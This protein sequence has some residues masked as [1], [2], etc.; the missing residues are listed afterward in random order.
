MAKPDFCRTYGIEEPVVLAGMAMVAEPEL[1]A[2]VSEAGGLGTLGTGGM[3]AP[4]LR[5]RIAEVRARTRR[6]FGVNLIVVR[7][8]FEEFSTDAQ[9]DVLVEERVPLVVFHWNLPP[10]AWILRLGEAGLRA[11]RTVISAADAERA[12]DAGFDGLVVQGAEAGGHNRS[13]T[14]LAELLPAVARLTGDAHVIAAGGIADSASARAAFARG[15]DAV[16][17]GTRFVACAESPAHAEWKRRIVASGP[18]D[19]AVTRIFGPEWPDAPMRVLRNRAVAR[20]ERGEP[21][22]RDEK[23]IGTSLLF[24]ARYELPRCSVLL[25]TRDTEGDFDEMCLAAGTSAAAITR[26]ETAAEIVRS[27]ARAA[28]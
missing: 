24:G 6:P 10:P 27:I 1:V 3:P 20:A 5:A 9:I 15:A 22:P 28:R 18:G 12:L 2:A 7:T 17:L 25:P 13:E 11:W 21:P 23:P 19:T 4:I 14:P 8:P 16:C 26:I